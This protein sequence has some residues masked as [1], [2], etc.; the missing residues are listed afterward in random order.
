MSAPEPIIISTASP[1]LAPRLAQI[2]RLAFDRTAIHRAL[3]P[4]VSAADQESWR[5][6]DLT[7]YMSPYHVARGRVLLVASL[8][9]APDEVVGYAVW[10]EVRPDRTLTREEEAAERPESTALPEGMAVELAGDFF[11]RMAEMAGRLNGD[12]YCESALRP[13]RRENQWCSSNH[14]AAPPLVCLTSGG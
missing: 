7:A 12:R 9:D 11:G 3:V 8:G 13:V 1:A 2:H 5:A 10:D 4:A 14:W 6:A